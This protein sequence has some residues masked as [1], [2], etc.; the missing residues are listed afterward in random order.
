MICKNLIHIENAALFVS[1]TF[2]FILLHDTILCTECESNSGE[3]LISL[4]IIVSIII[5]IAIIIII[6]IITLGLHC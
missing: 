3:L 2:R 6:S 5:I 4:F 1:N